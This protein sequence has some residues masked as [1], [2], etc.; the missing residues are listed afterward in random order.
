MFCYSEK[1]FTVTF[2]LFNASLW[3]KSKVYLKKT[4]PKHL[5]G[6]YV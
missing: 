3:I 6:I 2:D 4:D 1:A 5:A